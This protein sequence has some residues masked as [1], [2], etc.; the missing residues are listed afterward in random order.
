MQRKIL[1]TKRKGKKKPKDIRDGKDLV[2]DLG[3][4]SQ[5][6]PLT[7]PNADVVRALSEYK[8]NC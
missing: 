6:K 4:G 3:S 7:I 5:F 2:I 1:Q 8:R